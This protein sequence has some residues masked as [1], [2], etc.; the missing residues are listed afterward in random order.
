MKKI[1][2]LLAIFAGFSFAE[3]G[4]SL[5]FG[6]YHGMVGVEYSI[7]NQHLSANIHLSGYDS[8]YDFMGGIGLTYRFQGLTGPYIFHSSEW[9]TGELEGFTILNANSD[10]T[11]LEEKNVDIN[12][13]RLIFGCG[14]QHMFTKH[15]GAYF[16]LGFQ[17]YA[18]N[19]SYYTNF[20]IDDG[21]L[22]RDEIIF[23]F[24]FGIVVEL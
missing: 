4:A 20:D 9:I 7:I 1:F 24:G 23:P 17:F 12:Y 8:D 11:Y 18:G 15:F 14:Y 5:G 19:G 22:N 16:E 10:N 13:W 3:I 2:L 21:S 6:P